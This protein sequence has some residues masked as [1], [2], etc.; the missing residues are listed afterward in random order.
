MRTGILLAAL[1]LITVGVVIRGALNGL[2]DAQQENHRRAERI[3]EHGLQTALERL[4][5]DSLAGTIAD[6]CDG[7]RFIV[8]SK[9]MVR[10]DTSHLELVAEGRIATAV[11]VR[12]CTLVPLPR[13][14]GVPWAMAGGIRS[15]DPD[16]PAGR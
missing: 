7:G 10:G 5:E 4:A 6:S 3:A 11:E 14:T 9:R 13:N 12:A 2:H 8:R 1:T 15:V 16:D